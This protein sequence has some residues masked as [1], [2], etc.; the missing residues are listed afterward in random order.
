MAI[1]NLFNQIVALAMTYNILSCIR[2]ENT[3]ILKFILSEM[4]LQ[5]TIKL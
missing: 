5:C 4:V 1:N 3:I 2:M